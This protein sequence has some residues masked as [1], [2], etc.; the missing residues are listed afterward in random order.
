MSWSATDA[1]KGVLKKVLSL[2]EELGK[3]KRKKTGT[4]R[5]LF[6]HF[7]FLS[8]KNPVSAC[9]PHGH[10]G[11]GAAEGFWWQCQD[12]AAAVPILG[13]SCPDPRSP[14]APPRWSGTGDG[15]PWGHR[16]SLPWLPPRLGDVSSHQST[17]VLPGWEAGHS[18]TKLLS[19][20]FYYQNSFLFLPWKT[21]HHPQA[22]WIGLCQG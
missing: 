11:S 19:R 10:R 18:Y 9:S 1:E 4:W 15:Q 16:E 7:P 8:Q 20:R 6:A 17:P 21:I 2:S 5:R 14:P 22:A 13:A 12:E 3:K